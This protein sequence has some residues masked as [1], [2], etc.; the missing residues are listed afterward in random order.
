LNKRHQLLQWREYSC[1][2]LYQID[3]TFGSELFIVGMGKKIGNRSKATSDGV[4]HGGRA[5]SKQVKLG[6]QPNITG[7]LRSQR[8]PLEELRGNI[9]RDDDNVM[10][11][12]PVKE[13]GQKQTSVKKEMEMVAPVTEETTKQMPAE[14]K[15]EKQIEPD[16]EEDPEMVGLSEYEKIR[17]RNIRQR[18][19]LFAELALQEAKEE[20]SEASRVVG[21]STQAIKRSS[22]REKIEKDAAEPVRKSLRLAGGKVPEIKRFTFEQFEF[23]DEQL[24]SRKIK[25]ED[26]YLD[27]EL[28]SRNIA[29]E[30]R[31][32]MLEEMAAKARTF[33]GKTERPDG[34]KEV[35]EG[36]FRI[37]HVP[38][39]CTIKQFV[40]SN[41]LEF[42]CG[43]GFYEFTKPEIVSHKK[44][45]VVVEKSSGAMFT[46]K[47]ACRL[48]G[49][50]SGMRIPPTIFET[51]QVFVQS[52][53]YGRNLMGGTD[54]LYEV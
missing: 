31:E 12:A 2:R 11:V 44:E 43:R 47:D 28:V 24:K 41:S 1:R 30:E 38:K 22:R 9:T 34:L 29:V 45:V 8:E 3:I 16:E 51:W 53:S 42:K 27:D 52:T 35:D 39:K 36:R 33:T 20:A 23:L 10:N 15:L 54:F 48:I 14:E 37:L 21:S 18:E 13:K 46:G 17:L 26:F 25:P 49:A 4:K 50:G 7:F 19:A 40:L 32:K 6:K 5:K